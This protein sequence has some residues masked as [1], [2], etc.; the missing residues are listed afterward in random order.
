M[1]RS[2]TRYAS[3]VWFC[4][5][6]SI[7]S[8]SLSCI[9]DIINPIS[10]SFDTVEKE[11]HGSR[12]TQRCRPCVLKPKPG[13]RLTKTETT[14]V[15]VSDKAYHGAWR[16]C[17]LM[18]EVFSGSARFWGV[19]GDPNRPPSIGRG[20]TPG[21]EIVGVIA[22]GDPDTFATRGFKLGDR[23]TVAQIVPWS[24]FCSV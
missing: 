7:A 18:H 11:Y 5:W 19:E 17:A 22:D 24:V 14:G 20:V 16:H 15:C 2:L 13:E 9:I 4:F 6:S 3:S 23:V 10:L 8:L 12:A 21:H 1:G